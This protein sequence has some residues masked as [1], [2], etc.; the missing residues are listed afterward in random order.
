MARRDE[1][2][3]NARCDALSAVEDGSK[4]GN[5]PGWVGSQAYPVPE[6]RYQ[7]PAQDLAAGAVIAVK[8]GVAAVTVATIAVAVIRLDDAAGKTEG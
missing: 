5:R 8:P 7:G 1:T 3:V 6:P 2:N 4:P